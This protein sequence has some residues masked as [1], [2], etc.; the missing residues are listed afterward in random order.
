M[1]NWIFALTLSVAAFSSC[2]KKTSEETTQ[3][4]T[5]STATTSDLSIAPSPGDST[6]GKKISYEGAITTEELMKQLEGKDSVQVKLAGDV[7]AVCQKRGCWM[8]IKLPNAEAM[9]VRFKDYAFFVPK[10]ADGKKAIMEG[11]AKREVVSVADQQHYAQDAGDSKE[12]IAA[13]TEPKTS[14]TFEAE[15]VILKN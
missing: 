10:D 5:D 15:G 1:K 12:K 9:K 6:Y 2:D 13:I 3:T 11:W 14:Y 7:Q 8:D 4:T